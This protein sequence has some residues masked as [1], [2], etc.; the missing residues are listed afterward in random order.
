HGILMFVNDEIKVPVYF[1]PS[2]KVSVPVIITDEMA[3]DV[4]MFSYREMFKNAQLN[5]LVRD[6]KKYK[7]PSIN[8]DAMPILSQ[9]DIFTQ[10][11]YSSSLNINERIYCPNFMA[12]KFYQFVFDNY[13]ISE[14]K[15]LFR[16]KT[17]VENKRF[18]GIRFVH[19]L[20]Y[21]CFGKDLKG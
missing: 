18:G 3:P 15:D 1:S 6:F 8:W 2:G 9:R 11:N 20:C 21:M 19:N 17:I 16:Y 5:L 13:F 10:I 4:K 7:I 12:R 14:L